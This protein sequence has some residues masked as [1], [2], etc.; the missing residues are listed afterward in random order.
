MMNQSLRQLTRKIL[1]A[2]EGELPRAELMPLAEDY[3]RICRDTNERLDQLAT[4]IT[5]ENYYSALQLAESEPA[6]MDIVAQLSF[7]Q[8]EQWRELCVEQRLSVAERLNESAIRQVQGLYSNEHVD[9]AYLYREYRSSILQ[10]NFP[11]ALRCLRA[12]LRI[13][14]ADSNARD[15]LQR[16]QEKQQGVVWK[17]LEQALKEENEDQVLALLD[18]IESSSYS[19]SE[20]NPVWQQARSLRRQVEQ[21]RNARSCQ[22]LER[23]IQ[24][25]AD[26]GAWETLLQ[27]KRNWDQLVQSGGV[28]VK[29]STR[30]QLDALA[31]QAEVELGSQA[32]RGVQEEIARQWFFFLKETESNLRGGIAV[33]DCRE[34][35]KKLG[36]FRRELLVAGAAPDDA[37]DADTRRVEEELI[38][39]LRQVRQKKGVL[40]GIGV[41]AALIVLVFILSLYDRKI[42]REESI[43]LMG[44]ALQEKDLNQVERLLQVWEQQSSG[45]RK[46][47]SITALHK[48]ATQWLDRE[49]Q[50]EA[51]VD[52]I[53]R[54]VRNWLP[55]G[56]RQLEPVLVGLSEAEELWENLLP[57]SRENLRFIRQ[58]VWLSWDRLRAEWLHEDRT[59]LGRLSSEF[60][61]LWEKNFSNVQSP[62]DHSSEISKANELLKEAKPVLAR[63]TLLE[64][65]PL[66]NTQFWEKA[67]QDLVKMD[68]QFSLYQQGVNL[69][70]ENRSLESFR[71]G[72]TILAELPF[73]ASNWVTA[74]RAVSQTVD[75]WSE[76]SKALLQAGGDQGFAQSAVSGGAARFFPERLNS[77]EN[78]QLRA[79]FDQS[80]ALRLFR[81]DV[82]N[83][84][85]G[86]LLRDTE[87]IYAMGELEAEANPH[88]DR[89]EV[90]QV[91]RLVTPNTLKKNPFYEEMVFMA[92][93]RLHDKQWR[94]GSA[95]I[96]G[97]RIPEADFLEQL[98]NAIDYQPE[99]GRMGRSLL[100][101]LDELFRHPE[102]D[103]VFR[104]WVYGELI[105][106]VL[107]R[108]EEWGVLVTPALLRDWERLQRLC[109]GIPSLSDWIDPN[110]STQIRPVI[111]A[112]F[113]NPS[114]PSYTRQATF[115]VQLAN[116]LGSSHWSYYG[117]VN[118][119]GKIVP[120]AGTPESGR[121]LWGLEAFRNRW[122]PLFENQTG[123]WT[124]HTSPQ[125]LTPLFVFSED[126]GQL[127]IQAGERTGIQNDSEL[128]SLREYL[129]AYFR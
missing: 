12:I 26:A 124:N 127:V 85:N 102:V 119:A 69:L 53:Y 35:L 30:Q 24:E 93:R 43:Q 86:T 101:A 87:V 34:A 89:E 74:S 83:Y 5:R 111:Q 28:E 42:H 97:A 107:N 9:T 17:E 79:L 106:V 51:Q 60:N 45:F 32:E 18:E 46:N 99:S 31:A 65:N 108:P 98:K 4:L 103:A 20:E 56:K 39:K 94:D 13:N 50:N 40:A 82:H 8:S 25:L 72:I 70:D 80:V 57:A 21:Q 126:L 104:A 125:P 33:P 110:R 48:E 123:S 76:P 105:Q 6:V 3:A 11:A 77:S 27:R 37:L 96:N 68:E 112:F 66:E 109:D 114:V 91:V 75:Q 54:K 92:T 100:Y 115:Q 49:K 7:A 71:Y 63:L 58:E 59:E 29:E 22:E 15:E 2:I 117:Y 62:E 120:V 81:Y 88:G 47:P 121:F 90:V 73:D 1:L 122:A 95:L 16:L 113:Q 61:A 14:P 38:G 129:P 116:I 41:L 55:M 128:Q 67:E 84:R 19:V 10:K 23:G 44:T 36:D 64:E 78:L 118:T 52:S